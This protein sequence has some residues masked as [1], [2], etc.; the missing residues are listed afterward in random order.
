MKTPPP[1]FISKHPVI[2]QCPACS[3][4]FDSRTYSHTPG[5]D[6]IFVEME[7]DYHKHFAETHASDSS[8]IKLNRYA[9]NLRCTSSLDVS[10]KHPSAHYSRG[11]HFEFHAEEEIKSN[12]TTTDLHEY[13][14]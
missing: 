11:E 5:T 1:K 6:D 10:A 13:G 3:A 12:C 7:K 9:G 14:P 4:K 8:G 2:V